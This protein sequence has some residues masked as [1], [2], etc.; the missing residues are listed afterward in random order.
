MNLTTSPQ[1][2]CRPVQSIAAQAV[3][4]RMLQGAL[5]AWF[6]LTA[7]PG[8][9]ARAADG[10]RGIPAGQRQLFLEDDSLASIENLQREL[11]Q[12]EKRGAVIRSANPRQTIQIRTAPVWDPDARQ[13]KLWVM[14]TDQS[15]RVSSD[16]LHWTT[17]PNPDMRIDH[18]VYDPQ[19]SD[20]GRRYK[21]ALLNEGFAV[22]PD[23]VRWTRLDLP[24][25]QSSDEGNLSYDPREGLFIHSVKRGGKYGRSVAIATSRDFKTW[26]DYGVVFEADDLDQEIGRRRIAER[27]ANPTLKQTEYNSPEHYSIQVYNMGVFHYEGLYIGMPSIY[28][29]T[30]KVPPGWPGFEKLRLSPAI[31]DA[32][33][34]YGDYT[35]FYNVQLAVSRDLTA[36]QRVAERRPFI[37]AS[38]LGAGAYDTQTIIGPSAPV[39]RDDELWFYYT[40][41]RNYA[42][43]ASGNEPGY[44][45]YF[46]DKGG[47]C[48]AVL[49]RD[50]FVSLAAGNESGTATTRPFQVPAGRLLVNVDARHGELYAEFLDQGGTVLVRST[51]VRGNTTRQE[52]TWEQAQLKPLVGRTVSLRFRMQNAHLY[53]Y[54]FEE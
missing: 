53:S 4:V 3:G 6:L 50:G 33:S 37:E 22:S 2:T 35:G 16:G 8:A 29:H 42:F 13:F 15:L 30:G 26:R 44:D 31:R 27:L 10:V 11:H 43:V 51:L 21:T 45:D 32:V 7:E 23:G 28:H 17:G 54:W 5:F 12:P 20:P 39:V 41:I 40:G 25:V 34:R 49:R 46:P 1:L 19:D 48:L 47:I 36:W 24:A 14:S 38:P 18:A 52:V 9:A